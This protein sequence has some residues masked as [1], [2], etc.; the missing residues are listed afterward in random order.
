MA[1]YEEENVEDNW[2]PLVEEEEDEEDLGF[3]IFQL[4]KIYRSMEISV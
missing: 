4:E 1:D 3:W 2:D